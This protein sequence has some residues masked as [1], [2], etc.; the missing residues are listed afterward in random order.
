MSF[1]GSP[2]FLALM[3]AV[4][5][6]MADI[7]GSLATRSVGAA[8]AVGLAQAIAAMLMGMLVLGGVASLPDQQGMLIALG[9][10]VGEA[11]GLVSLYHGLAHGR[12]NVVAPLTGIFAVLLPAIAE[13]IFI[14]QSSLLAWFGIGLAAVAVFIIGRARVA[15]SPGDRSPAFSVF[16]GTLA[17]VVFGACNFGLAAASAE[18]AIG[19]V[20]L[21]RVAASAGALLFAATH[22]FA[23]THWQRPKVNV[24]TLGFIL[25]AGMFDALGM[26]GFVKAVTQGLIGV[27]SA[28]L[29]MSVG[30]MILLGYLILKEPINRRQL[31]GLAIGGL[32]IV[33]LAGSN[34]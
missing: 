34:G 13:L 26:F 11:V 32:S 24:A 17:G 14:R 15:D 29:S 16:Y 3:A 9:I 7:A 18:A 10:G 1:S 19:T 6:G 31:L 28:L 2:A 8:L 12:I 23:T 30:V 20:F 21:M 4:A 5:F 25:F 27:S 22:L 33:L